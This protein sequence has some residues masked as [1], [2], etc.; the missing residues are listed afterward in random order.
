MAGRTDNERF[1]SGPQVKLCD[2]LVTH[3]PCL[4]CIIPVLHDSLLYVNCV[5]VA[6]CLHSNKQRLLLL[7]HIRV[8]QAKNFSPCSLDRNPVC[9]SLQESLQQNLYYQDQERPYISSH[10]KCIL[11]EKTHSKMVLLCTLFKN[12]AI[13]FVK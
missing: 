6:V 10:M 1:V 5:I 3:G 12:S 8:Y 13:M 4:S 2:P 11:M 9:L 7:L